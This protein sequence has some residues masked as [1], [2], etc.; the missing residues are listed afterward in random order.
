MAHL[1]LSIRDV[2]EN[3]DFEVGVTSDTDCEDESVDITAAMVIMA[4]LLTHLRELCK[5]LNDGQDM[6]AIESLA[7]V[8]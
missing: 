8:H 3:G 6:I 7:R 2:G 4:G 1:T 5:E